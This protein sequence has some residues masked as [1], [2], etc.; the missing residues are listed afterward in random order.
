MKTPRAPVAR[1]EINKHAAE[2]LER[3]GKEMREK[4]VSRFYGIR[5]KERIRAAAVC[6]RSAATQLI[7]IRRRKMPD[8]V[9]H[10]DCD[11]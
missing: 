3:V 5:A 11:M 8:V 9:R 10:V 4:K 7:E 6:L 1:A 2:A